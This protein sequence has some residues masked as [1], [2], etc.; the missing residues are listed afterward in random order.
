MPELKTKPAD[1]VLTGAGDM[2]KL[3]PHACK[4][5]VDNEYVRITRVNVPRHGKP[6][7]HSPS[8]DQRC[9]LR[10]RRTHEGYDG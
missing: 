10:E 2:V 9:G 1:T 5:E 3:N 6:A 7:M 4:V 8:L